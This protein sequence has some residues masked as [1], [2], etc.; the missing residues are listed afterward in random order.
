MESKKITKNHRKEYSSRGNVKHYLEVWHHGLNE[1]REFSS[2]DYDVLMNKVDAYVLKLEEKWK[3]LK[4]KQNLLLSKESSLREAEKR[5]KSAQADLRAMDELLLS[6]LD[7]DDA[8]NWDSLKD[9][10]IFNEP[11]PQYS[12]DKQINKVDKPRAYVEKELPVK[13]DLEFIKYKPKFS[14]VDMIFPFLKKKKVERVDAL[15]KNDLSSWEQ[16]V[17]EISQENEEGRR[18]YEIDV[19]KYEKEV[20]RVKQKNKL[21]CKDWMEREQK[22]YEKQNLYN[23]KVDKLKADYHNQVPAA[24][25]EACEIVL[26][27]SLYPDFINKNFEIDYNPENKILIVEYSLPAPEL[28]PTIQEVKFMKNEL[29][30]YHVSESQKT[31]NY[32]SVIYKLTLRTIHELF[33]ADEVDAL[34]AVTFNGWVNSIDKST[35]R[36]VNNCIVSIQVKKD[37]FEKVDLQHVD[38]KACFKSLKG[39]GSSK[40]TGLSAV[41]PILKIDKSDKRFVPHYDV[42]DS[43]DDTTNI[44]SMGWEDFEH[45]IREVFEKEFNQSGGEVKVTQ[46]SKDG[47]VDVIAFDPD[48]IRGGKIVIQAKRYTN[49]VGVSAVRDLY[50]TVMNEGATK[51]ILVTTADYGP[52]A[53][54]FSKGKPI[55]L[56]N[57]ANLLYLLEKHGHKA[58]IDIREAKLLMKGQ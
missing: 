14:L 16:K 51:G 20:E 57:G 1:Y 27:N 37:E 7:I 50:G 43:L 55:T 34:N 17:H 49:T 45:L 26:S 28:L 2:S 44:A 31:K 42:A 19:K 52:D 29:K 11:N 53:Y 25:I 46:A 9:K 39:V 15:Y 30:E 5:T 56:M 6:T 23:L 54:E 24:I 47:G 13:P 40:L 18:Q 10:T 8:I 3:N 38:P 21:E 35:G 32:D 33:E 58:K 36:R 12:L 22:F 41:Q 4:E 48:P